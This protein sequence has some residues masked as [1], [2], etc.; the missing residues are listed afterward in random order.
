M[1]LARCNGINLY[2]EVHG[3][4]EPLLL[5]AGRG[6]DHHSWDAVRGDFTGQ[7]QVIVYDHA[8]TGSSD[9]VGQQLRGARAIAGDALGLLNYLGLRRAHLFGVLE[10]GEV[11]QWLAIDH[12]ER[13]GAIVLGC[14]S[15]IDM[16]DGD[17]AED[18]AAARQGRA[19][20]GKLHYP[21]DEGHDSRDRLAEMTAPVLV[22]CGTE[23][24]K[25]PAAN[26]P[27]LAERIPGAEQ[28][29]VDVG[30]HGYM[31]EHRDKVSRV[32]LDFLRRNRLG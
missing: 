25:A 31:G 14:S 20:E 17:G 28:Y 9:P 27:R 16:G 24:L 18:E 19:S 23:D 30:R 13:T 7:H 12:P 32:V 29:L 22:I 21:A 3:S 4:G 10:G 11:C 8:D 15:A 6:Q 5:V 2:Y 1:P 26:T